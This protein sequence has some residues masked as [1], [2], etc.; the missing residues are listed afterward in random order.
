MLLVQRDCGVSPH[1]GH[2][3]A[4]ALGLLVEENHVA[5]Q[6]AKPCQRQ[7]TSLHART[8]AVNVQTTT[9]KM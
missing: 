1:G 7:E 8:Y 5:R 4:L 6:V 3:L 2:L 9:N